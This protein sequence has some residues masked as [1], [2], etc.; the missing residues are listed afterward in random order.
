MPDGEEPQGNGRAV[1]VLIGIG[2]LAAW[3]LLLWLMFADVL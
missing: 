3:F 2:A 1:A